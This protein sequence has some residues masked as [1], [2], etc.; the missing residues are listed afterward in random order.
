M[1]KVIAFVL[2]LTM[3]AMVAVGCTKIEDDDPAQ[4]GAEIDIYMGTKVMNLDPAIAYTDENTIKILSLIYEGLT[5]VG[6]NGKLEKALAKKWEIIEDEHTGEKKLEVTINE[7]YWSDGSVVQANDVV[8]AWRRILSPTFSSPAASMLYCIKGARAAKL[9]EISIYDIGLYSISTTKFVVLFE[10]GADIDEFLMNTASPALVPLRENKV[11]SYPNTWSRSATD[12]STNGPFRV[13]KFSSNIH[14]IM[15]LERSKYYYLNQDVSTEAID[16]FVIPFRLTIHCDLPLDNEVVYTADT[17]DDIRSLFEND[18]VFYV[19]GLTA[20]TITGYSSKVL[21]TA[22]EASTFVYYFN[23]SSKVFKEPVVRQ[24]LSM[25]LDRGEIAEMIGCGVTPATGLLNDKVVNTKRGTSFR[26]EGGEVIST[27][28]DIEGAKQLLKDADIWPEDYDE[29]YLV[30]RADEINDSYRSQQMGFMNKEKAIAQ[31][32]KSVW[33]K[34]GFAVTILTATNDEYEKCYD[35]GDYDV[36]GLDY[37]MISTLP[38][39]DLAQF[40]KDYSGNV[41]MMT[42]GVAG[43]DASLGKNVYYQHMPHMTGYDS[44]TFNALIDEAY[45]TTDASDRADLLHEAEKQLLTDCAV[46]PIIFNANAYA[47]SNKLSGTT[48]NY[49]GAQIFT[50]TELKDYVQYLPSVKEAA[51]KAAE[52]EQ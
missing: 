21:E 27:T 11:A 32:T 1:K 42:S 49:W 37:Q 51:Q 25:A 26:K 34:L 48:T 52:S 23:T 43:F 36:I 14:E 45:A 9:G 20:S 12:I 22:K 50:S 39:Y 13:K 18:G 31:Y 17:L 38:L 24:A 8:Y 15:V 30:V 16:K 46:V 29:I 28:G 10:D 6:E 33:E 41:K 35:T 40:A 5:R 4:K 3:V 47:I 7:T 44:E 19:T 2:A